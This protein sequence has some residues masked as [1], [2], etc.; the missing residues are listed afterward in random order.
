MDSSAW[1]GTERLPL[2]G[3][4]QGGAGS[5]MLFERGLGPLRGLRAPGRPARGHNGCPASADGD[6]A[7][8]LGGGGAHKGT[9]PSGS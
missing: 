5:Q 6:W 4:S 9:G 1:R 2:P 3:H 8:L 7:V